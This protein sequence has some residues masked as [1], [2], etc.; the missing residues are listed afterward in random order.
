MFFL[1]L[2]GHQQQAAIKNA[3]ASLEKNCLFLKILGSY[4]NG[5]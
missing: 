3:V 4:P 1:D 2:R 5:R